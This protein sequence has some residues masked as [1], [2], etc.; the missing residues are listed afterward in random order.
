MIDPMADEAVR[1]GDRWNPDLLQSGG[2]VI[3]IHWDA[4]SHLGYVFWGN[5]SSLLC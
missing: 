1:I 3:I 4:D 5:F 2:G